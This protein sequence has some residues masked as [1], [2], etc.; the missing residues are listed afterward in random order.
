MKRK[1]IALGLGMLLML[2]I[3]A[4]QNKTPA[5]DASADA[6]ATAT[7]AQEA[8]QPPAE[9][10]PQEVH[11][12]IKSFT[13]GYL[14]ITTPDSDILEFDLSEA[15]L[16]C[17]NG[18][19]TGDQ[20]TVVYEGT[21]KGHNTGKATALKVIDKDNRE[22]LEEHTMVGTLVDASM[23]TISIKNTEGDT[24]TFISTGAKHK[25]K[26]GIQTGN[27][28]TV[29]YKGELTRSNAKNVKVLS[30]TDED[31][32]IQEE[33]DKV[34]IQAV[35]RKMYT[36]ADVNV[37]DTY[38]ATGDVLGVL[39]TG[40]SVELTGETDN[41]WARINYNGLDAYVYEIYLTS[42]AP[43]T[44]APEPEPTVE[45]Q[46]EK[47]KMT[48]YIESVTMNVVTLVS[49]DDGNEYVFDF[50]D[51]KSSLTN[52]LAQSQRIVVTYIGTP[53]MDA[54]TTDVIKV[55]DAPAPGEE[56]VPEGS[57]SVTGTV[58]ATSMNC[59]TVMSDDGAQIT[60]TTDDAEI[61]EEKG[62]HIGDYVVIT[63][64][65]NNESNV[66]KALEITNIY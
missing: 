37:R 11:G 27:W 56:D 34:E 33:Q 1:G 38:A 42:T 64:E 21:I 10:E 3:T 58:L 44:S 36:T 39:G 54:A 22:E 65:P 55:A 60:C 48:G 7:P 41:G 19:L 30:I 17:E 5:E 53:S 51:A 43:V 25:Y 57:C 6:P 9:E 32:N 26:N 23:N 31:E 35:T 24:I 50:A 61:D 46:G 18:I 20:V 16:E 14:T 29:T 47:E 8:S 45:P 12:T 15:A 62:L 49:Q 4:C 2:S 66:Y 28:I 59:V 52:G 40:A 13:G 63:L